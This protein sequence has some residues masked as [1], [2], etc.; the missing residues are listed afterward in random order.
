MYSRMLLL[1]FPKKS[2]HEP[3]VC[4]LARNFDLS[5]NILNA[6]IF[7]RK[8]GLMVL[9][10]YGTRKNFQEGISYLEEQGVKV[11]SSGEEIER[12]DDRCTHCGTCTAVCPTGALSVKRPSMEVVFDIE[13]CSVCKLC[14]PVCPPRAMELRPAENSSFE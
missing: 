8:E 12:N 11:Q 2:V 3:V 14:L 13:K 1:R 9:K 5:F 4:N 6:T 10:L 7:P